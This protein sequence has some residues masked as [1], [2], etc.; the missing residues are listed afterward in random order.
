[1]QYA[2]LV[3]QF[4]NPAELY[5]NRGA[6]VDAEWRLEMVVKFLAINKF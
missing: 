4:N 2:G 3:A 5:G 1:M 6:L